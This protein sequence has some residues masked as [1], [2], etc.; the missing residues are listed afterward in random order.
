[1]TLPLVIKREIMKTIC[2]VILM[3]V[4]GLISACAAIDRSGSD[5]R[6]LLDDWQQAWNS[7]IP[8]RLIVLFHP[9]SLPAIESQ[10]TPE[11]TRRQ[12]AGEFASYGKIIRIRL[13]RSYDNDTVLATRIDFESIQGFPVVFKCRKKDDDLRFFALLPGQDP[14]RGSDQKV[15]SGFLK[16]WETAWNQGRPEAILR[17]LHSLGRIQLDL[18]DGRVPKA[19]IEKEFQAVMAKFGPIR[20]CTVK[21][22]KDKTNEYI[23]AVTYAKAGTILAAINLQKDMDGEWRIFSFDLDDGKRAQ[24]TPESWIP[25]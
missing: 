3:F 8:D 9:D 24:R 18:K 15:I 5:C 25:Q 17:Q 23:V 20:D 4:L 19:Q 12:L 16:R 6:P 14:T 1:M 7:A 21:G 13:L 22:Y 2:R 10:V 11:E